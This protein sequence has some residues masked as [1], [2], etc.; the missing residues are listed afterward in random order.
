[1]K[2]LLRIILMRWIITLVLTLVGSLWSLIGGQVALHGR[3]ATM[4][5]RL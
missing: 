1:M 4:L 5:R 3:L 2:E